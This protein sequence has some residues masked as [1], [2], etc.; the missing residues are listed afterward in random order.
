METLKVLEGKLKEQNPEVCMS[1]LYG[2]LQRT[3]RLPQVLLGSGHDDRILHVRCTHVFIQPTVQTGALAANI[4]D[5]PE[6][7]AVD[8]AGSMPADMNLDHH[9]LHVIQSAALAGP[10]GGLAGL[11][12]GVTG[13]PKSSE[14]AGQL[15]VDARLT[16]LAGTHTTQAI[17]VKRIGMDTGCPRCHWTA[18]AGP[19]CSSGRLVG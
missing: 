5:M 3:W 6:R 18:V 15:A 7:T 14:A 17:P 12:G 10:A 8:F 19:G 13:P 16:A 11:Q 4:R 9:P 2:H 1:L